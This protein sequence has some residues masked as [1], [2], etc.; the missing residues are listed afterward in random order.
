MKISMVLVKLL[1]LGALLIISNHNL[2]LNDSSERSTFFSM[3][4]S[5]IG[6]LVDQGIALS[7]YVVKFEWLPHINQTYSK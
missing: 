7:S 1:F 5:W 4:N 2:H 6:G 3:Y